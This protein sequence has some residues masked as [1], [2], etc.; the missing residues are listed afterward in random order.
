MSGV[1]GVFFPGWLDEDEDVDYKNT[2][3]VV[4]NCGGEILYRVC[5]FYSSNL[6]R[7]ACVNF[8][9]LP[10]LSISAF[11]PESWIR[12]STEW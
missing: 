5:V 11:P 12:V 10:A 6:Y 3:E 1:T 7:F 4:H 8:V 9:H 2:R